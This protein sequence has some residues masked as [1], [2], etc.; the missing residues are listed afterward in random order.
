MVDLLSLYTP[1]GMYVYC[2]CVSK[3][4]RTKAHKNKLTSFA[5]GFTHKR[6]IASKQRRRNVFTTCRPRFLSEHPT[7]LCVYFIPFLLPMS[8]VS[9]VDF[10]IAFAAFCLNR[11]HS[12]CLAPSCSIW[13]AEI[14]SWVPH[15]VPALQ[16]HRSP[17]TSRRSKL[18][19]GLHSI[20]LAFPHRN[21][22]TNCGIAHAE[23]YLTPYANV[24]RS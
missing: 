3:A 18:M 12:G 4:E 9:F 1:I 22:A 14:C 2:T 15:A 13:H 23:Q 8:F 7:Y 20:K 24:M 6:Q 11:P 21:C 19:N 10:H 16:L 5:L 17:H